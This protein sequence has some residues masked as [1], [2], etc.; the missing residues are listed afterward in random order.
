MFPLPETM[1]SPRDRRPGI[2]RQGVLQ[3][4]VTRACDLACFN[5]T[6]GSNLAGKPV[7]ITPEQF[8]T[9]CQSLNGYFG[10]VGVF[11]GNPA[12]HP[13]F[14]EL[15]EI[16]RRHIPFE[17]RGLWCN[18][19]KGKA[20]VMRET[21]NPR[22][23][24]LNV[25]LVREAYD[26]FAAGWPEC[27]P[28]LK[29]L[30]PSW[31][32]AAGKP[33]HIVGDARHSPPFVAMQDVLTTACPDCNGSGKFHIVHNASD[34]HCSTCKGSG[35]V[36]DEAQAWKLIGA[37]DVNQNWSSMI[38]VFRGELRGWFCELAGAQAML[39][40]NDTAWPDLGLPI[41]PGWWNQPMSA[42]EAQARWHCHRCGIPLRGYGELAVGGTKEQCSETHA[43]IYTPKKSGRP[44][45]LVTLQTQLGKR[46]E[47]ATDYVQN[48]SL[49]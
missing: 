43:D 29:G 19:P 25:H 27:K 1:K 8:E 38:G 5:C 34:I 31:P 15:C 33:N 39:H 47:R 48:G 18:H 36:Y 23:S 17:Q 24:N 2:W 6:Q 20:A 45:E 22:Y 12:M 4:H 40:Q 13:K 42:F 3:I 49:K 41:V 16:M 28:Y 7:M 11:G 21:F 44:V 32:E 46:L 30:D 35:A 10:V 14:S 37:C 9:A 26:E